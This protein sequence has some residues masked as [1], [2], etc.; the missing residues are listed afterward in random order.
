MSKSDDPIKELRKRVV[1]VKYG[2]PLES[3]KKL[4]SMDGVPKEHRKA[5]SIVRQLINEGKTPV[6]SQDVYKLFEIYRDNLEDTDNG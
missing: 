5:V 2:E 4:L 3:Y 6:S 1:K